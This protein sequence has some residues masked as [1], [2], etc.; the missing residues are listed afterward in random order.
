M[1]N[2]KQVNCCI[3]LLHLLFFSVVPVFAQTFPRN[4]DKLNYT[5]VGFRLP[6]A[7]GTVSY[8]VEVASGDIITEQDFSKHIIYSVKAST[9]HIKVGLPAFGAQYTWRP[10]YT[11]GKGATVKGDL[12]HFSTLTCP[13]VDTG[14]SHLRILQKASRY[15]GAYVFSDYT[16]VLYDMK[17]MPVWFMP[18]L[19][20]RSNTNISVR[21]LKLT[22]EGTITC[23]ANDWPYEM[24]Y[25]GNILWQVRN[26]PDDYNAKEK[27]HHEFTRL[28]AG[29]Y[30]LLG[31]EMLRCKLNADKDKLPT[32]CDSSGWTDAPQSGYRKMPFGT[33][34][35]YNSSN[36]LVWRWSSSALFRDSS[37][38]PYLGHGK[39]GFEIHLNSFYLDKAAGVLYVS[40]KRYSVII[41]IKYPEGDVMAIYG[42]K[43]TS[44]TFDLF[45]DQHSIKQNASGKL[46]VFNNNE[47]NPEAVPTVMMLEEGKTGGLKKIWEL[48]TPVKPI[49]RQSGD[50]HTATSGGNVQELTGGDIFA[51]LS[52][53]YGDM[54]IAG[55][56]KKLVWHGILERKTDTAGQWQQQAQYRATLANDAA[57][58]EKLLFREASP[59][60]QLNMKP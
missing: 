47:C 40:S 54:F 17:G 45:C 53:P 9:N 50:K 52:S 30:M 39:P 37:L 27:Y 55:K 11:N 35:E 60:P 31:T 26:I 23:L 25:N 1:R 20:G 48:K 33:V 14:M 28:A 6:D 24:D 13:N 2:I 18:E 34:L 56:D 51:S 46:Y 49:S 8:E 32:L 3:A 38:Y 12:I 21:D 59:L 19:P 36:E 16:R 29:N 43:N 5:L 10:V 44:A 57:A 22:K 15:A 58:I 4:G 42:N 41:K 7:P